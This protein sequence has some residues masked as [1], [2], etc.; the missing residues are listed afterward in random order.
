MHSTIIQPEDIE[1]V[2]DNDET[3]FRE[4]LRCF[5]SAEVNNFNTKTK[6]MGIF[7][8]ALL[9]G[10]LLLHT[11]AGISQELACRIV[12]RDGDAALH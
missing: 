5:G 3:I 10:S 8:Q 6:L 4:S 12:D 11:S 9:G 7:V 1:E 2:R